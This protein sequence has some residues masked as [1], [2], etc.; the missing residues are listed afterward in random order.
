M[1]R[2][3]KR[4]A[5]FIISPSFQFLLGCYL[6]ARELA[7]HKV[8]FFQF[9]LGCYQDRQER[10]GKVPVERGLFQFL[11][12]CYRRL[13]WPGLAVASASFNSFW[14]ATDHLLIQKANL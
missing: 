6:L 1:L 11:L 9:L 7:E 8:S 14:D 4:K 3:V 10:V 5:L 13:V 2:S 12:G